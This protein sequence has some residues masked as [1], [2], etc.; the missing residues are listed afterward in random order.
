MENFNNQNYATILLSR[1]SLRPCGKDLWVKQTVGAV[2]WVKENNLTLITSVGMKT[3]ELITSIASSLSIPMVL[4]IPYDQNICENEI[5]EIL[6]QEFSLND[7][8]VQFQI[9][10][11]S[12]K[13][14]FMKLRDEWIISNSNIL[15]PVSLNPK[16]NL[17]RLI[18]KYQDEK[19]IIKS[20]STKY[21]TSNDKL[22]Y[23]IKNSDLSTDIKKIRTEYLFHWTKTTNSKWQDERLFDYYKAIISTDKYPR[24]AIDNLNQIIKSQTIIASS[25]N[26]KGNNRVVSFSGLHPANAISL[27]RWRSRYKEMTIEPYAIGIEKSFALDYGIKPVIY[28]SG[29]EPINF[30]AENEW[31]YQAQGKITDWRT[32]NEFRYPGDFCLTKIPKDKIIFITRTEAEAIQLA[33][34]TDI[35]TTAL[36]R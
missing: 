12:D 25:K 29:A 11:S 6:I 9:L 26:I 4:A 14:S 20:F 30:P 28:Y 3:W 19:E 36:C 31:L 5:E 18:N 22:S 35:K 7:K 2:T 21:T 33:K 32:E 23:L 16:G 27:M 10:N 24:L 34:K 15:L 8:N 13:H 1:Q 17:N